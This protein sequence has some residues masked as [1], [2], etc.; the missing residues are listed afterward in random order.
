M[1]LEL[2]K[3]D[4]IEIDKE[5]F[6]NRSKISN[7]LNYIGF[8]CDELIV[9]NLRKQKLLNTNIKNIIF[10]QEFTFIDNNLLYFEDSENLLNILNL[11]NMKKESLLYK[12]SILWGIETINNKL[13]I[14]KSNIIDYK[15]ICDFFIEI[16]DKH[17]NKLELIKIPF[18]FDKISKNGKFGCSNDESL[19]YPI[20]IY[21]IEINEIIEIKNTDTGNSYCF[22]KEKY[23]IYHS[24]IE[25]TWGEKSSIHLLNLETKEDKIIIDNIYIDNSFV[26]HIDDSN[27]KLDKNEDFLFIYYKK[28]YTSTALLAYETYNFTLVNEIFNF[29]GIRFEKDF[30]IQ[31]E[32]DFL[33][34]GTVKYLPD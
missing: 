24:F 6:S 14:L 25:N 29:S 26:H 19:S 21:N 3:L 33:N 17:L 30:Y 8:I 23:F 1:K 16:L 28:N 20:K 18:Y 32:K 11:D 7:D 10:P 34:I 5:I 22:F 2:N 13:Y 9:L 15:N 12:N 31:L 27:I 4:S